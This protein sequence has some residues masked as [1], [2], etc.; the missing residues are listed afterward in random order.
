[1]S[2]LQIWAHR[3][4]ISDQALHELQLMSLPDIDVTDTE[5]EQLETQISADVRIQASRFGVILLRNNSGVGVNPAGRPVR[6]GLGNDSKRLNQVRKSADL[7]GLA[8]NG[9]FIAIETKRP[10]WRY[11]ATAEEIAQRNFLDL[12]IRMNG[13]AGFVQS[14]SDFENLVG[15]I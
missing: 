3:W 13:V 5:S 15:S 6:F 2:N 1:M 4:G 8:P 14:V 11:R 12:V 9:R 10:G 7:I